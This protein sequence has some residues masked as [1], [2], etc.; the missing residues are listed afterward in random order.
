[1]TDENPDIAELAQVF[2]EMTQ[3][4]ITGEVEL[5]FRNGQEI[6]G[7]LSDGDRESMLREMIYSF[8]SGVIRFETLRGDCFEVDPV[9]ADMEADPRPVIYLDQC[10]WSTLSNSIFDRARVR[11]ERD[12]DAAV[13][14]I[15]W[16]E[17]GKIIVPVSSA[18]AL[19]TSALF[20]A[21]RQNLASTILRLSR[22][23][24]MR[25]PIVVRMH[26]MASALSRKFE[27]TLTPSTLDVFSLAAGAMDT[28]RRATE[29]SDLPPG[30]SVLVDRLTSF[31]AIYDVLMNP[32]RVP[33]PVPG[34]HEHYNAV[35]QDPEFQA[36]ESRQKII[37]G[38]A[39]A[40]ADVVS[41][42]L[43]VA[44]NL[45]ISTTD[46]L[47]V[48]LYESIRSMPS[49]G[50][51]GDVIGHRLAIR[52][53]WEPNDLID[54]LFLGCAAAYADVVV[55]E[56][57][58]TNYLQRAWGDRETACPVVGKL[59]DAVERISQLLA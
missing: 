54:M 48:S 13:Q 8:S 42:A 10:H 55:A 7:R 19:E 51:Y 38:H 36:R 30:V 53:R 44:Q 29:S 12:A 58:A 16:A 14:I 3:N 37:D 17:S 56:R 18:H 23:W 49:M 4:P 21:R 31:S 41:E 11:N 45:A 9:S 46:H 35:S 28:D 26:E 57:V 6:R 52:A 1:M 22:G 50:L 20:D 24:Q 43:I 34:W 5:K 39:M 47:A 33:A 25:S 59:P 15:E 27:T 2:E 40:V 32:E